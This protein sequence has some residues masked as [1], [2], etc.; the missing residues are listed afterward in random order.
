M[1]AG[2]ARLALLVAAC[3]GGRGISRAAGASSSPAALGGLALSLE[4]RGSAR[5]ALVPLVSA[6]HVARAH[7][8]A[9]VPLHVWLLTRG[10]QLAGTA[11]AVA[12]LRIRGIDAQLDLM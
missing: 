2:G 3:G 7:L 12:M 10:T 6:M 11:S 5:E 8:A 1:E 4:S 9:A